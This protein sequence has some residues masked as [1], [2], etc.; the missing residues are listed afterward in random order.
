MHASSPYSSLL[1]GLPLLPPLLCPLG[2]GG[3]TVS[4]GSVHTVSTTCSSSWG[5]LLTVVPCGPMVCPPQETVLH[6]Y[7]WLA[8]RSAARI[9][10]PRAKTNPVPVVLSHILFQYS[11]LSASRSP[12]LE[13]EFL[14]LCS[15][16]VSPPVLS[17]GCR[18]SVHQLTVGQKEV[19]VLVCLPN[20]LFATLAGCV[21]GDHVVVSP[22]TLPPPKQKSAPKTKKAFPNWFPCLNGFICKDAD[23]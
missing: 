10:H 12:S 16:T 8:G 20:L 2:A 13:R 19:A 3:N 6:E 14:A 21:V 9:S 17:K 22:S 1:P 11:W 23:W 4:L 18:V 15:P 7:L 5:V